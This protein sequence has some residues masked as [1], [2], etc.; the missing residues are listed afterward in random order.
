[1][2]DLEPQ[3]RPGVA[4]DARA[5]A[6]RGRAVS[7]RDVLIIVEPREL[8]RGWMFCWLERQRDFEVVATA[9]LAGVSVLE[10]AA[11]VVVGVGLSR[12]WSGW[13]D[14][15]VASVRENLPATPIILIVESDHRSEVSGLVSRLGLQG[16]IPTSSSIEVAAA[17]I[18]QVVA[19]GRF[20]PYDADDRARLPKLTRR[21]EAV[22]EQL[23][24]GAPDKIIALRLGMSVNTVK[25]H[26]RA[27]IAKFQVRNR[28]QAVLAARERNRWPN[29][30]QP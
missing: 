25:A 30:D 20:L 13:T 9:D 28:T 27:I 4:A 24:S 14:S 19:G 1:M 3:L 23:A 26:V 2:G 12:Q 21:Q 29:A 15:Q 6:S 5:E 10:R 16:V 17:V 7:G 18:R 22:L 11:A 8:V